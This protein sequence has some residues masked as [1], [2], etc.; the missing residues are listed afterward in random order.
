M[1]RKDRE[2][3]DIEEKLSIIKQCKVCRLGLAEN[4]V[5]Y[6]VPLNFGYSFE[7]NTLT[8]FFHGAHEGKKIA[9]IKNNNKACFEIDCDTAL[10]E[11][12]EACAYSYAFKSIIGFGEILFLETAEE[13]RDGLNK[14]MQHQTGKE[15]MYTFTDDVLKN[16]CVYKIHVQ[17]F[18]G[19]QK[20]F[21]GNH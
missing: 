15:T 6:I 10:I 4:N 18:T 9:I 11:G 2:I 21:P 3:T 14:I 16:V 8:L 1:R 17:E 13:K 5:P 12:T 20:G 19:K 7:N